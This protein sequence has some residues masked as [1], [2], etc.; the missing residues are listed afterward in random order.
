VGGHGVGFFG[1]EQ[2][3]VAGCYGDG[4][5]PSIVI[6][7]RYMDLITVLMKLLLIRVR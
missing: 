2:G 7:G 4:N 3:P 6:K 5:D 1:P